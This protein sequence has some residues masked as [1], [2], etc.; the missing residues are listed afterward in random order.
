MKE[1]H[2]WSARLTLG[3]DAL[4][5]EHHLQVA[6]VTGLADA[7]ERGRPRLASRLID[8]LAGYS[9][10]HFAGEELL[11]ELA[12]YRQLDAHRQEHRAMLSEIEEIRYLQDRGEYL[13]AAPMVLDLLNGLASHIA[14][15]DRRF[16]E[17]AERL[18]PRGAA[19]GNA[20]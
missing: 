16:A 8:Q 1:T 5:R 13:L 11:M 15:S 7:I 12:G 19:A 10:A 18:S 6:L 4:D 20:P 3:H 14:A 17:H 9:K 2:A